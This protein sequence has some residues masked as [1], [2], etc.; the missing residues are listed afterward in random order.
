MR[1]RKE[2][3]VFIKKNYYFKNYQRCLPANPNGMGWK[4]RTLTSRTPCS[5]KHWFTKYNLQETDAST[6]SKPLIYFIK[7][8]P[9]DNLLKREH[10]ES[11]NMFSKEWFMYSELLPQFEKYNGKLIYYS[12]VNHCMVIFYYQQ[13]HGNGTQNVTSH[14]QIFLSLTIWLNWDIDI[15]N[16][17]VDLVRH[18]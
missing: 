1:C 3:R 17:E 16:I 8:L 14:D 2:R 10:I 15:L 5:L 7:S 11:S 18:S 12:Y 4:P 9:I 6:S 13:I